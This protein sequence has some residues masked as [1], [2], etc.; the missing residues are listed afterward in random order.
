MAAYV[1]AFNMALFPLFVQFLIYKKKF[2][3]HWPQTE[4]PIETGF[5][6]VEMCEKPNFYDIHS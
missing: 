6:Q 1:F 5:Y 4:W 3:I 2:I